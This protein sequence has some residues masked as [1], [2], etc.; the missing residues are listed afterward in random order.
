[1]KHCPECNFTFPDFHRVCD[2]DGAELVLD[3][4][5]KALMK[6]EPRLFHPRSGL[7]KPMLLTSLA[8]LGVFLSAVFVGYLESPAP[9]IPA[10]VR[11]EETEN[12]PR[13]LT[14]VATPTSQSDDLKKDVK[15]DVK[16]TLTSKRTG[17]R[18]VKVAASST[19]LHR[20]SAADSRARNDVIAYTQ[21]SKRTSSEKSPPKVVAILKTTWRFL[22]KPFDF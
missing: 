14:P 13:S 10:I 11:N 21:N 7:I 17:S 12:A 5:R 8:V 15:N 3:P 19:A 18:S 20:K 6:V 9:S 1:M 2:F 16:K 22:K 4:E